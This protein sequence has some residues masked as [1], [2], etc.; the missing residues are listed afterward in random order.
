MVDEVK[1]RPWWQRDG[2]SATFGESS[3]SLVQRLMEVHARINNRISDKKEFHNYSFKLTV[4]RFFK[5][6]L[7]S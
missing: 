3:V 7:T 5:L 6:L 2:A 1:E 4:V